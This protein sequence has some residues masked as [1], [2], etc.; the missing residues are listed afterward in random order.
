MNSGMKYNIALPISPISKTAWV[1]EK[2]NNLRNEV[3]DFF[4]TIENNEVLYKIFQKR[5]S[6]RYSKYVE[7]IN[8]IITSY[9]YCS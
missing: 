3:E 4:R 2:G 7:T 5:F 6:I 9:G 8:K 1:V